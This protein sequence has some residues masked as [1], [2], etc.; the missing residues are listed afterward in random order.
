MLAARGYTGPNTIFEGRFGLF[1]SHVGEG[2]YSLER[3]VRGLG[4]EWETATVMSKRYPCCHA[5][6]S[7]IDAIKALQREQAIDP[8]QV[9][10]VECRIQP[11]M[12]AVVG[13]PALGKKHPQTVFQAQFS[14]YYEVA[15]VLLR[16]NVTLGDFTEETIRDPKTIALA[17]RVRYTPWP[18]YSGRGGFPATVVLKLGGG[19]ELTR[20]IS[21]NLD[22]PM[23]EREIGEKFRRN[24]RV[25]G[26]ARAEQL[27]SAINNVAEATSVPELMALTVAR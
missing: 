24:A 17:E 21:G 19:R 4:T 1:K 12:V 15:T 23:T 13:E 20:E 25:L 14:I 16:G 18:A 7:S 2:N 6:H 3:L 27:L 9:V 5:T 22:N 8:E 11:D 10:E 26:E